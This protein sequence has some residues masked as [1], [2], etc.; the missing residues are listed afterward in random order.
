MSDYYTDAYDGWERNTFL[1]IKKML[2][3]DKKLRQNLANGLDKV[4]NKN[5]RIDGLETNERDAVMTVFGLTKE[6]IRDD[7]TAKQ[8]LYTFIST[9]YGRLPPKKRMIIAPDTEIN[10]NNFLD[11]I[12][13]DDEGF[14][15]AWFGNDDGD[16]GGSKMKKR[17]TKRR[18][19]NKKSKR[20]RRKTRRRQR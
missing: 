11:N 2:K 13:G 10:F 7:E 3:S 18:K 15:G 1:E 5:Q 6:S 19:T 17:K 12:V 4:Y 16:Y 20:K 14:F 8:N 9:L